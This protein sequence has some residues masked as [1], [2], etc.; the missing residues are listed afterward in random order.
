MHYNLKYVFVNG[1]IGS[2]RFFSASCAN[3]RLRSPLNP[4]V[5]RKQLANLFVSACVTLLSNQGQVGSHLT[6][7]IWWAIHRVWIVGFHLRLIIKQMANN[8]WL[9]YQ[10]GMARW[11]LHLG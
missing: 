7:E 4:K 5:K 10:H 11:P 9:F 6:V 3:H 8:L 2:C 1:L